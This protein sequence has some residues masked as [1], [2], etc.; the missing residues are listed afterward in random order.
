MCFQCLNDDSVDPAMQW[1]LESEPISSSI[2]TM[3]SG[4]LAIFTA[5]NVFGV[6]ESSTLQCMGTTD[7]YIYAVT[8]RGI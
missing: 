6:D 1:M 8:I 7:T 4:Y 5:V 2:G 3:S